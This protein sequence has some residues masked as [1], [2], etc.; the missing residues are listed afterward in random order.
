MRPSPEAL[1]AYC[2]KSQD[3]VGPLSYRHICQGCG[4]EA[5]VRNLT[6]LNSKRGPY[7]RRHAKAL[8]EGARKHAEK[9]GA[10]T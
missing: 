1:C 10:T 7:A 6:Q 3:E 8:L 9:V 4:M 2:G 5:A